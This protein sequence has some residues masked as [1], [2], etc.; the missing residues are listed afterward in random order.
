MRTKIA[1]AKLHAQSLWLG[2]CLLSVSEFSKYHWLFKSQD[3][4]F[5]HSLIHN[6]HRKY[7]LKQ[8]QF[9]LLFRN[10]PGALLVPNQ[11]KSHKNTQNKLPIPGIPRK[12]GIKA[13]TQTMKI[14]FP[15]TPIQT[16]HSIKAPQTKISGE[17]NPNCLKWFRKLADNF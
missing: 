13:F 5:L 7:L 4:T 15:S 8:L 16:S 1:S 11:F 9:K 10:T 17:N 12:M 14:K 2:K 6:G 3:L